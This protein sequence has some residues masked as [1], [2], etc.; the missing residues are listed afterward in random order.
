[1]RGLPLPVEDAILTFAPEVPP[2]ITREYPVRLRVDMNTNLR[3]VPL[4]ES[5]KY[6]IWSFNGG[7]PGPFIRARVGDVLDVSFTNND[8]TGMWHNID[9]HS[10]IGPG[11]GAPVLTCE[12]NE[13]KSAQFHLLHPGLF[14]Y[15][16]AVY[17]LAYHMAN[18]MYGIM[19]VEPKEGLPKVDREYYVVQSEFY[20]MDADEDPVEVGVIDADPLLSRRR[21]LTLDEDRLMDEN[22]T[23]VVFN[24]MVGSMVTDSDVGKP[25]EANCGERVRLYFGNAGPNLVSSFH[26][27]GAILDKVWRE[28]DLISPPA[29]SLQTTLVPAGGVSVVELV[30]SIPGTL[31]MVD[32][33]I[34]RTEKGA[35]GFINVSGPPCPSVYHSDAAPRVCKPCKIHP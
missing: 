10:V 17:P 18:G 8:T 12:K 27:I 22:P 7:T 19:L 4:D 3:T 32:H 5:H 11:G 21:L 33:S 29:R 9:F 26:V 31:T 2:P 13:T 25:L 6:E 14:I 23:H 24:G 1:M 35:V 15:H 16:C 28:G 30:P 34:V 20:A